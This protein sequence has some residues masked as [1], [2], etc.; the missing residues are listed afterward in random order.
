MSFKSD[1]LAIVRAYEFSYTPLAATILCFRR[2]QRSVDSGAG[3]LGSVSLILS[4]ARMAAGYWG[5]KMA[6][7]RIY[8]SNVDSSRRDNC[9]PQ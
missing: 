7:F 4:V 2:E 1:W 3:V 9:V 6:S 5:G 8:A